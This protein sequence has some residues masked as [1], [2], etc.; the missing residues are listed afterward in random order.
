MIVA[1]VLQPWRDETN[2]D[3]I[4]P[5]NCPLG[6]SN[7]SASPKGATPPAN[8]TPQHLP[9]SRKAPPPE[10]N[11]NDDAENVINLG[12][13]ENAKAKPS[14]FEFL[15]VIGKGSFGK[16]RTAFIKMAQTQSVIRSTQQQFHILG[17][18]F[19]FPPLVL[20]SPKPS[21]ALLYLRIFCCIFFLHYYAVSF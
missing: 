1:K 16:V 2:N 12:E 9:P 8:A 14:D 15:K 13:T 6:S 11:G 10:A 18:L 20:I 4:R 19:L 21:F 17:F 5:I 7:A 3:A